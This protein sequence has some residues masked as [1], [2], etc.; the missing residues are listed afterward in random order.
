MKVTDFG[1]ARLA[2]QVPLIWATGQVVRDGTPSIWRRNRQWL[3]A[4][5]RSDMYLGH[6]IM[7]LWVVVRLLGESQIA[8]ALAQVTIRRRRLGDHP[9]SC[10]CAHHVLAGE[11][12]AQRP[13]ARPLC[14]GG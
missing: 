3:R 8:I 2:N 4:L 9:G 13:Y 14:R 10:S 12:P 6:Y 11:G 5:P 1:I 7:P